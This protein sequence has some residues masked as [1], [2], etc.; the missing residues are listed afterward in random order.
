MIKKYRPYFSI[1]E[2]QTIITALK[3]EINP[4]TSLLKYLER[5]VFEIEEGFRKANHT[6]GPSMLEKLGVEKEKEPPKFN[7][8][9]INK[10]YEQ[11]YSFTG[12]SAKQIEVLQTYRYN[13]NL[14]TPSE[15]LSYEE[16]LWQAGS[17][18]V[19]PT[20]E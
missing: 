3:N 19:S 2:I 17:H 20:E 18:I 5:Y 15:E 16:S 9:T 7:P 11:T 6:L 10:L 1:E 13:N 4:D 8:I 12:M 14:M